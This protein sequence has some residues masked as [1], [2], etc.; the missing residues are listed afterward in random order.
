MRIVKTY[1]SFTYGNFGV[2]LEQPSGV[3][4]YISFGG[5]NRYLNQFSTYTTSDK[6][7]Q[8]L[9]EKAPYFNKYYTIKSIK[10]IQDK[11]DIIKQQERFQKVYLKNNTAARAWFKENLP[12]VAV[13]YLR[14]QQAFIDK[15]KEYGYMIIYENAETPEE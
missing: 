10:E 3:S 2:T 13:S 9:L 14:N 1:Q 8:D 12:D 7:L 11:E 4:K 15:A 6:A 5:G